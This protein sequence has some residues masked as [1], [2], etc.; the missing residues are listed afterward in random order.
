MKYRINNFLPLLIVLCLAAATFWLRHA[1]EAPPTQSARNAGHEPDSIVENFTLRRLSTEGKPQYLIAAKRMLHYPDTDTAELV[2][3]QFTRTGID[4]V[5]MSIKADRGSMTHDAAE[6]SFS[7]HVILQREAGPGYPAFRAR[8]EFLEILAE[9]NLIRTNRH[10]DI[11]EGSSTLSGIGME[12][13]KTT[14]QF[15]LHSQARGSYR[16]PSRK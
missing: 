9:K 15:S 11:Q 7:G 10:V 8:T 1:I 6:A 2:S 12:F 3:P 13:N 4:G 5:R 14:R 16:A